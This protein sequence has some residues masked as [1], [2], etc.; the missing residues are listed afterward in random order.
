MPGEA[1]KKGEAEG[2]FPGMGRSPAT[3]GWQTPRLKGPKLDTSLPGEVETYQTNIPGPGKKN[4]S[5]LSAQEVLSQ[6]QR[7]MEEA[8]SKEA[9]PFASRELVKDYFMSIK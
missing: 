7:V 4:P 1:R 6:Y 8:L 2:T 9:I 5:R 3:T